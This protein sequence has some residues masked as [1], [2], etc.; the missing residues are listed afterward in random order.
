MATRRTQ[1]TLQAKLDGMLA[2]CIADV[3]SLGYEPTGDILPHV[4]ITRNERSIG[5]CRE[6]TGALVRVRRGVYSVRPGHRPVFQISCSSNAGESDQ[7]FLDTLYHEVIHTLPGCFSHG[8]A[9]KEAARRVNA[10]FGANVETRKTTGEDGD[11]RMLVGTIRLTHDEARQ[12]AAKLVGQTF[13]ISGR[14]LTLTGMN[15]R[16]PKNPCQLEEVGTGRMFSAPPEAVIL[17]MQE[18][19]DTRH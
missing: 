7:E 18:Q 3:R 9:F 15:P 19:R 6:M 17:A 13:L 4:R 8:K 2:R 11:G 5:T 1:R 12:M 16:A 14:R 10:A